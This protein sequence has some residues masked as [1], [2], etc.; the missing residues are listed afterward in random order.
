MSDT[1]ESE[2]EKT[3]LVGIVDCCAND[4]GFLYF[5]SYFLPIDTL[6]HKIRNFGSLR[7]VLKYDVDL[8]DE[9]DMHPLENYQ[10]ACGQ[11]GL[12]GE[13]ELKD[14]FKLKDIFI[15]IP[16]LQDSAV[17]PNVCIFYISKPTKSSLFTLNFNDDED[18]EM[19]SVIV[20]N[21]CFF[22]LAGDDYSAQ[23]LAE[24]QSI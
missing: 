19:E 12:Y 14:I 4:A 13:H 1:L 6:K 18:D 22:T 15:G 9:D 23:V 17:L 11:F 2:L 10:Q 24:L 5:C 16:S 7:A 20:L 3:A 21:D 8:N